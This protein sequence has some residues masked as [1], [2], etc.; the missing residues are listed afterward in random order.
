[1]KQK[2]FL[3]LGS[4]GNG[5]S[6]FGLEVII[7]G[8]DVDGILFKFLNENRTRKVPVID[9][10]CENTPDYKKLIQDYKEMMQECDRKIE[11]I[12]KRRVVSS[13]L[14]FDGIPMLKPSDISENS[15]L[16][17]I[18]VEVIEKLKDQYNPN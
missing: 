13:K 18:H 4:Y 7:L 17:K 1:M 6:S 12:N 14:I 5:F 15:V 16:G 2:T 3:F 8:I 9:F 11:L 10:F